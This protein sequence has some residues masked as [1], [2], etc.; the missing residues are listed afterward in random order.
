M[1]RARFVNPFDARYDGAA[2]TVTRRDVYS[3]PPDAPTAE[4]TVDDLRQL[5]RLVRARVDID[6]DPSPRP[7]KRLK[8]SDGTAS[9]SA[10]FRL[11]TCSEACDISLV[12][13]EHPA[14][15]RE[16]A[17]EDT[18]GERKTRAARAEQAAVDAPLNSRIQRSPNA[19][20]T[21]L[22]RLSSASDTP[23][24]LPPLFTA[25]VP[26]QTPSAPLNRK[27]DWTHATVRASKPVSCCPSI[28]LEPPHEDKDTPIK[29]RRRR[30]P[31]KEREERAPPAFWRPPRDL[32]G[33]SAGYALGWPASAPGAVG[34]V[35][36]GQHT[37]SAF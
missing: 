22:L 31:G 1:Y 29:P 24:T 34:Y 5:D 17:A 26:K 37:L 21:R 30:R 3:P 18:S 8:L 13:K 11:F 33:K 12:P 36:C 20:L 4:E 15:K 28:D 10:L 9:S 7:S 23:S 27:L 35:R 14:Q 32:G 6:L 2:V 16:R 25:S 19:S